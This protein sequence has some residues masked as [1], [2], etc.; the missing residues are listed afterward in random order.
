MMNKSRE[1]GDTLRWWE[2]RM[3]GKTKVSTET[4][5]QGSTRRALTLMKNR[6][7]EEKKVGQSGTLLTS[8]ITASAMKKRTWEKLKRPQRKLS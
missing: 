7:S 5:T 2:E 8:T 4:T 3:K 6:R 1:K